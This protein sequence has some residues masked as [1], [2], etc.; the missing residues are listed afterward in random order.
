[1]T[2][3]R[4]YLETMERYIK[5]AMSKAKEGRII[6]CYDQLA[7]MKMMT[8]NRLKAVSLPLYEDGWPVLRKTEKPTKASESRLK[9]E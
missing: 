1:M 4:Q 5:A 2:K 3:E 8:K 6:D 7:V 9:D